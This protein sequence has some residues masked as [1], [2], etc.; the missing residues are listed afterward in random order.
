MKEI[1]YRET[2]FYLINSFAMNKSG[3]N[4]YAD[5]VPAVEQACKILICLARDS[6]VAMNLKTICN[7]VGIHNSKGYSIL[8]T[9]A[10]FGLIQREEIGKT[11]T[12]GPALAY[13]GRKAM[14]NMDIKK[15]VSPYLERL[16]SQTGETSL[17]GLLSG[18]Q[19][20]IIAKQ[21]GSNLIG[22]NIG[23]G[24]R[25]HMTAGAHG[26]AIVSAMD[27]VERKRVLSRKKLYFYGDPE[28]F[29]LEVLNGEIEKARV[30]GFAEDRGQLQPG[31]NAVS[32]AVL[33]ERGRVLGCIIL[34]GTY[35]EFKIEE[36]GPLVSKLARDISSELGF[37]QPLK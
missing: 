5:S 37:A 7:K 35:P 22:I 3:K 20:F 27:E 33:D 30:T 21:E 29:D 13:L 8:N 31:I 26:K 9:L 32:S 1:L 18:E 36:F 11:Y 24:H 34:I 17:F 28:K 19:V 2:F 12:L 4:T 15:L 14:E 23:I 25:F 10:K 16:S 6:S